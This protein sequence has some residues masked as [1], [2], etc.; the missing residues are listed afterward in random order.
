MCRTISVWTVDGVVEIRSDFR[1]VGMRW[2]A[3]GGELP[4]RP[5]PDWT[6]VRRELTDRIA[7]GREGEVCLAMNTNKSIT[8]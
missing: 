1:C 4:L 2:V 5:S 6:E 7:A 8:A 3:T